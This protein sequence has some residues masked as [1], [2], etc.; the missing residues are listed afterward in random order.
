[1]AHYIYAQNKQPNHSSMKKILISTVCFFISGIAVNAQTINLVGDGTSESPYLINDKDDLSALAV[2][3]NAGMEENVINSFEGVYF[4][5]EADID[6]GGVVFTPIGNRFSRCFGGIF[7]GNG[8]TISNLTVS[9]DR[10]GY[11]GLFGRISATGE[12][13]NITLKDAD[14][15]T[16]GLCAGGIAGDCSGKI[17]DCAVENIR[18]INSYQ[19]TGGIAGL[20]NGTAENVTV[21]GYIEG[22]ENSV[23][24]I[25]GQN[26]SLISN[27]FCSADVISNA[28][29]YSCTAGGISGVCYLKDAL[30]TG[31]C[32]AGTVTVNNDGL[33]CGGITGNLY[34]GRVEK[35]FNLGTCNGGS[36]GTTAVGGIAGRTD[37]GS[38]K[39]CYNSGRIQLPYGS[40]TIGGIAGVLSEDESHTVIIN[41]Y[42]VGM[43]EFD[44]YYYDPA[45][46]TRE[47]FGTV[48]EN[49][50]ISNVYFDLQMSA[51]DSNSAYGKTTAELTAASGL[52][53]FSA[54]VWT[55][56]EGMYP[57]LSVFSDNDAATVSAAPVM[58]SSNET[59]KSVSK[60]FTLSDKAEWF[61]ENDGKLG[62]DGNGLSINGNQ[63]VLNGQFATDML[64][65]KTGNFYRYI[66]INTTN[67]PFTG[68]GTEE[69]PYIISTVADL[70]TMAEATNIYGETYSGK[71]FLMAGDIDMQSATFDGIASD[72]FSSKP[73]AGIFDG[74]GHEIQNMVIDKVQFD[75]DGNI[76]FFGSY[77]YGGFF[78]QLAAAGVVRNLTIADDCSFRVF[79]LS[80]A[81]VG[82]NDGLIENCANHADIEAYSYNA[83]GITGSNMSNGIVRGCINTG[84]ITASQ[85][86]VGGI[87]GSAEGTVELCM[88]TGKIEGVTRGEDT[89]ATVGGIAGLLYECTLKSV[90]NAGSVTASTEAG[91]ITANG[92][93]GSTIAEAVNYGIVQADD[94]IAGAII[95][96]YPEMEAVTGVFYDNSLQEIQA[97]S[98]GGLE[99]IN[100][101]SSAE[102]ANP[103]DGWNAGK[104]SM[105]VGQYPYPSQFSGVVE[106]RGAANAVVMFA[107]GE[108]AANVGNPALLGSCNDLSWQLAGNGCFRLEDN[109]LIP[110]AKGEEIL[111]AKAG[112]YRKE[113]KIATEKISGTGSIDAEKAI[114]RQ[115]YF[116]V[117]GIKVERPIIGEFYIVSTVYGDGST[118]ITKTVYKE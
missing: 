66:S 64:V 30:I 103:L 3:V 78:G 8:K 32:F 88:N 94:G 17:T 35:S 70:R 82:S 10:D 85:W 6:M 83:G 86:S 96:A 46:E 1:M 2:A 72:E 57:R 75:G 25:A 43:V 26:S 105:A 90:V 34:K 42:N 79:Y 20:L 65:G 4:R 84:N 22:G 16:S 102:L 77:G 63:A 113:I 87:V 15:A 74:G 100:G 104:W 29:G 14:I 89:G 106:A 50:E 97:T 51:Y 53:G 118:A 11:A 91:G 19:L 60:N 80:G 116:T 55:F 9:T 45:T 27:A 99:G 95:G 31:S 76:D 62:K 73:F 108:R 112:N 107:T 47:L 92:D 115:D 67:I 93:T 38:I 33:F 18:L 37:D 12:I 36:G 69:S 71:H 54:E 111:T 98:D 56:S 39:D 68:E 117:A 41:C 114:I 59:V 109:M 61:V 58:L 40:T 81:V 48:S 5:M 23:G 101:L 21:T 49:A 44:N 52:P 7:D 13:R 110:V 24:G 28:T